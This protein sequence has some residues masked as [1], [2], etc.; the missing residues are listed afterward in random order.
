M[1]EK[2]DAELEK[3]AKRQAKPEKVKRPGKAAPLEGDREAFKR[4]LGAA[5]KSP[6]SSG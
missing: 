5:V 2:R 6:K 3:K 4:L 1:R